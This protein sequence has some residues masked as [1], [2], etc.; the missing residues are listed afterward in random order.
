MGSIRPFVRQYSVPV[1][2]ALVATGGVAIGLM[3]ESSARETRVELVECSRLADSLLA[4]IG[5]TPRSLAAVNATDEQVQAIVGGAIAMC[6]G[7]Q[8]DQSANHQ[9]TA[10]LR[11]QVQTLEEAVRSGQASQSERSSLASARESLAELQA[12]RAAWRG[13]VQDIV[14]ST[15]GEAQRELLA[16]LVSNRQDEITNE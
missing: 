2:A 15:L 7:S 14:G 8:V 16:K 10:I 9:Q 4:E 1:L 6:E 13:Q 12:L 11:G 3:P 5:I